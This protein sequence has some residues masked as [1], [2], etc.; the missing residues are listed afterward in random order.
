VIPTLATLYPVCGQSQGQAT[1]ADPNLA[2]YRSGMAQSMELDT[3]NPKVD[4]SL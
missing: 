2:P 3:S 4:Q 1:L